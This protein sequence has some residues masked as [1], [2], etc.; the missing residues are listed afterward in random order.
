MRGTGKIERIIPPDFL[1]KYKLNT[2]IVTYF[3]ALH[4]YQYH[5]RCL[6]RSDVTDTVTYELPGH[7]L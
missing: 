4:V 2:T 3:I 5:L 7:C 1:C 6:I